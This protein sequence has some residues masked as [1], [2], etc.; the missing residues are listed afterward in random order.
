MDLAPGRDPCRPL[1]TRARHQGNCRVA[2]ATDQ[3][4]PGAGEAV[5]AT[6]GPARQARPASVFRDQEREIVGELRALAADLTPVGRRLMRSTGVEAP[7]AVPVA[8]PRPAA[9]P[10]AP[11][12]RPS[13]S[14]ATCFPP[15]G[16][17]SASPNGGQHAP[18][19]PLRASHG[20][21]PAS[22][23]GVD[24]RLAASSVRPAAWEPPQAV[25]PLGGL[26]AAT[27]AHAD[28]RDAGRTVPQRR[29]SLPASYR[30]G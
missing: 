22:A 10:D 8:P 20:P 17:P 11:R 12:G 28:N 7:K 21:V 2:G 6:A 30:H 29:P 9:L 19:A 15:S 13:R 3:G 14:A 5:E 27:W 1:P 4:R 24:Q 23:N 25:P 26:Q 16:S 18:S